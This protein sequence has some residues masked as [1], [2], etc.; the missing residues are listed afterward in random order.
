MEPRGLDKSRDPHDAAVLDAGLL[1]L[2]HNAAQA[3]RLTQ[4]SLHVLSCGGGAPEK[5]EL[6]MRATV[7]EL[8]AHAT[9]RQALRCPPPG[10]RRRRRSRRSRCPSGWR[11]ARRRKR[12]CRQ[13]D[14][15]EWRRRDK[16][17]S[18]SGT[19]AGC[20]HTSR[21]HG[22]SLRVSAKSECAH[23]TKPPSGIFERVFCFSVRSPP[24]A[25]RRDRSCRRERRNGRRVAELGNDAPRREERHQNRARKAWIGRAADEIAEAGRTPKHL[26]QNETGELPPPKH[27]SSTIDFVQPVSL[28]AMTFNRAMSMAPRG[29]GLGGPTGWVAQLARALGY[30]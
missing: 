19:R 7:C 5:P 18:P 29:N 26:A 30:P 24:R 21:R 28:R 4:V 12:H 17:V 2:L 6:S 22:S 20:G 11:P 14:K 9:S 13:R 3:F 16:P 10:G 1:S 27:P 15:E 8:C 25:R 23:S